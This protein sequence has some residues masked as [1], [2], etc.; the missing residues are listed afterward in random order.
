MASETVENYLKCIYSLQTD[1]ENQGVSTNSIA[2][3]LETQAPSVTDMLKKLKSKG[4]VDYRKYQGARLTDEGQ[5]IAVAIIRRH[6][7]WEVFLVDQLH[8]KWDEV[9][10]IAEQLEHVDSEALTERL[11][12]F[13]GHPKFDPHGDPIP[14]KNGVL[15]PLS[16]RF[17][18][19]SLS[20]GEVGVIVGVNDS[21]D[22]FLKYLDSMKLTLGVKVEVVK[23]YAFDHSTVIKTQSGE[24]HISESVAKNI[25]LTKV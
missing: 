10:E 19:H 14:D 21:D 15:N 9:H 23:H 22:E 16:Q 7:L 20:E 18:L 5:R 2:E 17:S 6:R 25:L 13:L 3:K 12:S 24:R 4:L 1:N 11:D 8:F